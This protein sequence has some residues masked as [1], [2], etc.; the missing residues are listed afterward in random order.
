M[1]LLVTGAQGMLGRR[2]CAEAAQRGH[3]VLPTDLPDLDLTYAQ[4][5]FDRIGDEA[6][7]AVVHCAAY[8]AVDAAEDKEELAT[9]INGEAA[10]H[11]AAAAGRYGAFVVAMS[12][13]YVFSG[14]A[15]DGRPYVESDPPDPRTAYGRS[16]LAGEQAVADCGADH[17]IVRSAWLYGAGGRNFVDTMLE[18]AQDRDEV[19]VVTDQVGSPTWTGHLA[20]ALIEVAERR[21]PGIHHLAGGGSC[22]WHDLAVETF[23]RAGVECRVVPVASDALDRPAPRPPWSVLDSERTDGLRLAPWQDGL[24]AYLAERSPA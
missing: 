2:V 1:R 9:A 7:D 17:A 20:P 12:T 18:L 6:P 3:E 16:K 21:L 15:R 5:V 19:S 4:A 22:S 14:E 8:T 10:G 13:D 23:A 11:V 24:A